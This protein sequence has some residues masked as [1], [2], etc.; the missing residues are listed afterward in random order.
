VRGELPSDAPALLMI[1]S[2]MDAAGFTTLA[3]F[4][5]DR[6]VVTYDP[7]G[8]SRSRRTDGSGELTP[9]DH[10]ADLHRLVEALGAGPVDVFASS[11]GAVNAL[12]W[13]SAHPGDVRTLVA[14]EPPIV[15]VLPDR[16]AATAAVEDIHRTY[17]RSGMG[18][19]MAKF[20]AIVGHQGEL[21]ADYTERPAPDPATF[22][23][24]TEDDGSRDDPL[25][26]QNLRSCTGYRL[27]EAALTATTSRV[28]VAG[29]EESTAEL[30][31]RAAAGVAERLGTKV[32]A[33][34]S[35]HG[36]FLGGEYGQ[37]G[38][39]EAFAA[40]LREVLEEE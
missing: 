29:G 19:A 24:P 7:R 15:E 32:T 18:P 14:H 39:P 37:R 5:T 35:N 4:F 34:P 38:Q 20:I 13:V 16:A 36:G 2:P 28:V 23:L 9:D 6:T 1:G 12:A 27:D 8:V 25:L 30:A 17:Q 33:F 3:G 10:A 40:R 11:G 31:G 21:P 22:G 26:G